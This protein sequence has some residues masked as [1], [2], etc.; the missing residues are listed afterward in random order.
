[1]FWL[2]LSVFSVH[3]LQDTVS[4]TMNHVT[5]L[6]QWNWTSVEPLECTSLSIKIR[7]RDG[8]ATSEWSKTQ[9][10]Q[11]QLDSN[12]TCIS[13]WKSLIRKN[14]NPSFLPVSLG[15][16]FVNLLRGVLYLSL[17]LHAHFNQIPFFVPVSVHVKGIHLQMPT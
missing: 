8:Q 7:S 2:I 10:L 6:H 12:F 13:L 17:R 3:S 15:V 4:A 16:T 1:M 14:K 5:G 11:G 9:I